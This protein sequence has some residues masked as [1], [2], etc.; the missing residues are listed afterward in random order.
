MNTRT[1]QV[2]L[3]NLVNNESFG[4][5]VIPFLKEEYFSDPS[6]QTVFGLINEYLSRYNAFPT[7]EALKIDLDGANGLNESLYAMAIEIIDEIPAQSI[8][9]TNEEW[10][11]DT[12]E[13]FCQDRAIFN[14]LNESVRIASGEDQSL[15]RTAIPS[16]MQEALSVSFD[17]SIGHDFLEDAEQRFDFYRLKLERIEFDI[18]YLNLITGGG[19]P[20]KTLTAL[21][22]GTG[23][24]KSLVMCHMA[25][26]NLMLGN[27]VLYITLEMAEE[28][29]AER[30]DANLLDIPL[31]QMRDLPFETYRK[32]VERLREKVKGKLIIKE[33][34]TSCA[35]SAN[36]RHLL[37]EL[38]IKKN[39]TPDVVYIDY[40]N[41]CASSRLKQ[42]ANVNSYTYIKAI[43][44]ELRGLAVEFGVPIVT[45]TQTTRCLSSDT[46]VNTLNGDK[47][48]FDI[49]EGDK[50]LSD[51]GYNT[52]LKKFNE[53]KKVYKITLECGK[54]ILCSKE[55]IFPT[56]NGD[57]T[58]ESG[59]S[60][61]MCLKVKK[62]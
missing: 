50:I 11:L 4:R 57:M 29:I 44:E 62:Q 61:G 18:E 16:L 48:I 45:A 34:P 31:D 13:R 23:V 46:I 37:N 6:E 30:I 21:L 22:A 9:I 52:V 58:I 1:E 12:A 38:R 27:N 39:F 36:F 59:L 40:I 17:S 32:K 14:A 55:H 2:I 35:G 60:V 43:A 49:Y 19:L 41:I 20:K 24:G 10:L 53:K 8:E 51:N 26:N 42:G 5:K 7:K 15:S 25:A 47:K 56:C 54:E 28:R 3:N 33:Y